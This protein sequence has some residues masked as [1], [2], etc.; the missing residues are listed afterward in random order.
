MINYCCKPNTFGSH[1]MNLMGNVN[2]KKKKSLGRKC[3]CDVVIAV[4]FI[5]VYLARL[6]TSKPSEAQEYISIKFYLN[7]RHF[8]FRTIYL[9]ISSA[10]YRPLRLGLGMF[11]KRGGIICIWCDRQSFNAFHKQAMYRTCKISCFFYYCK[12]ITNTYQT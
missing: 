3:V 6:I 4:H 7:F 10:N 5:S 12:I 9:K 2:T 11:I 8:L 1:G